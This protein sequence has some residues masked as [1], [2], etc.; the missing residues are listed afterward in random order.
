MSETYTIS[1]SNDGSLTHWA[2]PGI[3][4][5]S[6]WILVRFLTSEPRWELLHIFIT[7]NFSYNGNSGN[8]GNGLASNFMVLVPFSSDR[9]VLLDQIGLWELFYFVNICWK[10]VFCFGWVGFASTALSAPE[11]KVLILLDNFLWMRATLRQ[12]K[13]VYTVMP[14]YLQG[15]GSRTCRAHQ[16]LKKMLKSHMEN[17]LV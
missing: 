3:K 6:S 2:G 15:I 11:V 5:G 17:G 7:C 9:V 10:T 13:S 1:H 14:G 4:P 8:S 12:K 16:N